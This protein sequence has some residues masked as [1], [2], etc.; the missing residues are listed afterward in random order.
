MSFDHTNNS[1]YAMDS[2]HYIP[3]DL[4]HL[5]IQYFLILLSAFL[6]F[7]TSNQL[8]I[9][10]LTKWALHTFM[11]RCYELMFALFHLSTSSSV[12]G[13]KMAIYDAVLF[14]KKAYDALMY[15]KFNSFQMLIRIKHK[16]GIGVFC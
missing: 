3:A 15:F 14:S 8:F 10:K 6:L 11:L 2:L 9:D 7:I 4:L 1:K 16:R 5:S 13:L 12:S